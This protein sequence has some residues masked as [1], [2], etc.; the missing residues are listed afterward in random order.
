M[1][2][3]G[4]ELVYWYLRLN[5]FFLIDNFVMHMNETRRTSD[6]DLLAIRHPYVYEDI[7]GQPEDWDTQLFNNFPN[8]CVIGLIC[9]VK[10]GLNFD[11]KNLFSH[12]NI[13]KAVGRFG[14]VQNFNDYTKQIVNNVITEIPGSNI[15]IGKI[16]F[17]R[18]KV[19]PRPSD[20]LHYTLYDV[21]TF[22]KNRLNKYSDRK[23]SDR[24][25][26]PSSLLQYLTWEESIKRN[27]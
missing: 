22:I 18:K 4:E 26:F 16:L 5:G 11:A 17:S 24:M 7:G 21:R 25:F 9:E 6:T 14:F 13:Y 8:G 2:N 1:L 10:T 23:F 19:N 3:F 27:K 20:C 12:D 15:Q